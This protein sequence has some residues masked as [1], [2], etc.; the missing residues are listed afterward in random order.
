M[1]LVN[2]RIDHSMPGVDAI[3]VGLGVATRAGILNYDTQLGWPLGSATRLSSRAGIMGSWDD[4]GCAWI[5]GLG[6]SVGP[7]WKQSLSG[8]HR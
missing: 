7:G 3:I 2:P 8:D 4:M 1:A 5:L 6:R